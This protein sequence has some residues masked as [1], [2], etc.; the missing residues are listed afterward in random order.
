MAGKNDRIKQSI[1]HWCLET[2]SEAWSVEKTCQATKDLGC[3]AVELVDPKDWS[4]VKRH[5]LIC[6]MTQIGMPGFPFVKGYNNLNYH[7][8]LI[9]RSKRTIDACQEAGFPSIIAFTGYKWR[10]AEDPASGEISL[11]EGADNCVSGLKALASYAEKCGVNVC[12]E[13]LNT[14]DDSHPMKGHPGYQG[15]DLDYIASIVRRV[16]SPRVKIL[17]DVYHVQLMHG[18]ILRRLEENKD[19]LGHI[20]VAGVPG[21]GELNDRQEVNY[22]AVMHK[23]LDLDYH[24]Y[25]GQEFIPTSSPLAGLKEAVTLCD[26]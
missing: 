14:R 19:I 4:T 26:V 5:G 18:D 16:G 2:S 11:E 15:D 17:F 3:A 13:H 24:G 21:R 7:D 25:V 22:P 9:T 8:E 10:E 1:A 6:A 23:L 12:I 20:H